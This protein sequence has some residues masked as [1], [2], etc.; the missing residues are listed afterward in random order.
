MT[1]ERLKCKKIPDI[2]LTISQNFDSPRI[3][4]NIPGPCKNIEYPYMYDPL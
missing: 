4:D 3:H 1:V 2:Y